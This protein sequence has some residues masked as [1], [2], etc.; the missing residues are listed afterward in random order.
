MKRKFELCYVP[1]LEGTKAVAKGTKPIILKGD[2]I[3]NAEDVFIH[4]KGQ[5]VFV[6]VDGRVTG[7]GKY[8]SYKEIMNK[9]DGA[10]HQG[11]LL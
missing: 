8:A 1:F 10:I 5:M 11:V 2:P 9:I 6:S 7:F 4:E 3:K